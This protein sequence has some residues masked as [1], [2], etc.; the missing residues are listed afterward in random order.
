MTC[1]L[2]EWLY[3]VTSCM[4]HVLVLFDVC[5]VMSMLRYMLSWYK[6]LYVISYTMIWLCMLLNYV[7]LWMSCYIN[8]VNISALCLWDIKKSCMLIMKE[9]MTSIMYVCLI[10]MLY[11]EKNGVW[12]ASQVHAIHYDIIDTVIL[13]AL[14]LLRDFTHAHTHTRAHTYYVLCGRIPHR[15]CKGTR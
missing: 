8:F 2:Y 1:L 13:Y 5:D 6:L 4:C 9:M 10:G 3:A 12:L 7:V 14:L 11:Q 15:F